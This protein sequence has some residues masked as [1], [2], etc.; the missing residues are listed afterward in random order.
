MGRV[1]VMFVVFLIVLPTMAF[2]SKYP[3]DSVVKDD[4]AKYLV[5]FYESPDNEYWQASPG[6]VKGIKF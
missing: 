6:S 1:F 5:R 3:S 2:G 4:L